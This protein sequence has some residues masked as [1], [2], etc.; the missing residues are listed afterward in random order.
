MKRGSKSATPGPYSVP[1]LLGLP[2]PSI[3]HQL[4]V[5]KINQYLL[6]A[7]IGSG[8]SSTVFLAVD[9]RTKEQ[10]AIKRIKLDDFIRK[11]NPISQLEREI[12]LTRRFRHPQVLNLVEVLHDRIHNE[13]CM[14]LEYADAGSLGGYLSRGVRLPDA[15]IFCI[16]RQ[17]IE[18]VSYLHT[19]R[20]VHLDITPCNILLH[21]DGRAVLADF[22]IG[23][24]FQSAGLVMGSPAFQAPEAVDETD[25]EST[26]GGGSAP[27]K[28]D[29][30]SLGVTL[31]Q[32]LF[33][34]LPYVG[35]DL[36]E[37]V[38]DIKTNP[39]RLPD[40]TDPEI[41][42]LLS[43][44]LCVDPARR[45]GIDDI[46]ASP[47]M[48]PLETRIPLPPVPAPE[49]K[50]GEVVQ[51]DAVVCE[52][53]YTFVGFLIRAPRRFSDHRGYT[54]SPFRRPDPEETGYRRSCS[55]PIMPYPDTPPPP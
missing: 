48:P 17:V 30:W 39:L 18:A 3:S 44:M 43:G 38:H 21:A 8:A 34:R 32:S 20:F 53:T 26:P 25:G 24:S 51:I 27:Q 49:I 41:V 54:G 42:R 50:H 36:W 10:Y 47:L 15:T 9:E 13:V 35:G 29:V 37:I 31:Y 46:L 52:E 45:Y 2:T 19:S 23:H 1:A 33:L 55:I 12:R 5:R 7:K 4:R 11:G 40:G 14:V 22:G 16:L 28:E 6:C